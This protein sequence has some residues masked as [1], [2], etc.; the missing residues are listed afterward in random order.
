M[1][2]RFYRGVTLLPGLRLNF[3][4]RGPSLSVGRRGLSL[5][6]SPSGVRT[7]VGIPGSGISY[8]SPTLKWDSLGQV[9]RGEPVTSVP[10]AT[11]N[12]RT[13]SRAATEKAVRIQSD[14]ARYPQ[15]DEECQRYLNEK[16]ENW[17][18]LLVLR[19]MTLRFAVLK[20]DWEDVTWGRESPR[21]PV[22][23]RQIRSWYFARLQ[24]LRDRSARLKDLYGNQ[25][26]IDRVFGPAGLAGD[27]AAIISWVDA[28]SGELAACVDW[29]REVQTLRWYAE[30]VELHQA[31]NGLTLAI[32]RPFYG[33]CAS[34]D[35]QM[36][37]VERTKSLDL[38]VVLE[39]ANFEAVGEA[40]SKISS[41][42]WTPLGDS[43]KPVIAIGGPGGSEPPRIDRGE[44]E[45]G[46]G[47]GED[48]EGG[49][50]VFFDDGQVRVTASLVTI[51]P[52]WNK[53]FAISEIRSVN[54]GPNK[55][56]SIFRG[57]L[58]LLGW[59]FLGLGVAAGLGGSWVGASFCLLMG[60]GLVFPNMKKGVPYS[61]NIC[62]GG[63]FETEYL[64]TE[65]LTWAQSVAQAIQTAI[66][67]KHTPSRSEGGDG[68]IF[69]SQDRLK[70]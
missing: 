23:V 63:F 52:P 36:Q 40:F 18:W 68:F 47:G 1:G 56:S 5:N 70:N 26:E 43:G 10:A 15:S 7:T 65:N 34:L 53:A 3:S 54:Y 59:L 44:G 29:E 20:E 48:G 31:M 38:R 39:E 21:L 69:P 25:E 58:L 12:R 67:F 61:V 55:A 27:P 33:I 22:G 45:G 57:P 2:F 17:E 35:R 16:P 41:D 6:L 64:S 28:V 13:A 8:R 60:C 4:K 66:S 30:G 14:P 37:V 19:L 46:G 51:G 42:R 50:R 24:D 11:S 62:T 49:E 32:V 9:A